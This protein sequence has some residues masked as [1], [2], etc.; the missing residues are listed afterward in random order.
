MQVG[1]TNFPGQT[2]G[3][4]SHVPSTIPEIKRTPPTLDSELQQLSKVVVELESEAAALQSHLGCV[5]HPMPE[6]DAQLVAMEQLPPML[7][8]ARYITQ[9]VARVTQQLF[10]QRTNLALK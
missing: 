9:Q 8:H 2:Y 1:N 3:A 4:G 5:M 7:E 6:P 10:M